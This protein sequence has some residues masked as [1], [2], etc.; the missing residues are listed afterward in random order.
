MDQDRVA[1]LETA[2]RGYTMFDASVGYRLFR[3]DMV[4]ELL[5]SGT[6]LNDALALNHA[7]FLKEVAPLPGRDVRLTYRVSF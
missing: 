5:L 3:G 7:S 2:S 1:E 4:H 6:N